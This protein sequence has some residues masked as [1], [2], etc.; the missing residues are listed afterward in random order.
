MSPVIPPSRSE[1][2]IHPEAG[3]ERVR[4]KCDCDESTGSGNVTDECD[5]IP[6][7]GIRHF[8]VAANCCSYALGGFPNQRTSLNNQGTDAYA[9]GLREAPRWGDT[10]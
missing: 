9:L 8:C 6:W 2:V 7:V 10:R 3:I 5:P 4:P 1:N